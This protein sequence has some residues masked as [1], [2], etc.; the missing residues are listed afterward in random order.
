LNGRTIHSWC[1]MGI[2]HKLTKP[3]IK[4]LSRKRHLNKELKYKTLIIDEISMFDARRLDLV[5]RIC[6]VIKEPFFAFWWDTNSY[7]W[8]I[9]FNFRQ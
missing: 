5:D 1:G 2:S 6:K 8:C 7:V 3:Q 4:K 9:F